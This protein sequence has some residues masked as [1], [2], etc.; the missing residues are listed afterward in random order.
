M[1]GGVHVSTLSESAPPLFEP[2]TLE[3]AELE[4]LNAELKALSTGERPVIEHVL[5]YVAFSGF[6][7]EADAIAMTCRATAADDAVRGACMA[8]RHGRRGRT[9][10][11]YAAHR[12]DSRRLAELLL[13]PSGVPRP[14]THVQTTDVDGANA[15]HVM[16]SGPAAGNAEAAAAL[17]RAMT[18]AV[19]GLD[20]RCRTSWGTATALGFAAGEG[21]AATVAVLVG[22]GADPNAPGSQEGWSIFLEAACKGSHT[23][24]MRALLKGGARLDATTPL[25]WTALHVACERGD[26][27]L[28]RLLL[29]HGA[30]VEA[31]TAGSMSPLAYAAKGGHERVVRTLAEAGAE[32]CAA[33]CGDLWNAG[34]QAIHWAGCGGHT[35]SVQALLAA[36][37]DRSAVTAVG[38]T[39]L[40]LAVRA[41]RS[42]WQLEKALAS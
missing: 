11:M 3:L 36:G 37:A 28:A 1:D 8:A 22:A 27:D 20:G 42:S 2:P 24:I 4:V 7:A 5:Q 16:C 6:L 35:G 40:T 9:R 33:P 23:G 18:L 32:V 14:R 41:K 25:G 31:L 34:W 12:G 30:C 26:E 38:D 13:L 19:T 29:G 10:L 17:C 39:A 15:L 21:H